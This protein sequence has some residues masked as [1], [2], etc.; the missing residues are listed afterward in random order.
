MELG[1]TTIASLVNPDTG[2][3]ALDDA[4][5]EVVHTSLADE[6]AQRLTVRLK[7]FRGEWF[8][9]LLEGTPYYERV[10]TKGVSDRV[11]QAVFGGVI[12][13][14]QGVSSLTSL[15]YS[16]GSDRVLTL[17]FVAK[18]EDGT[19]FST[20]DYPPFVVV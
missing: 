11:I 12:R 18:L 16:L 10:L 14:T 7:F 19:T 13:G 4:G 17:S 9:N 8:L 3:L 6:V 1:V 15:T 2:D 5:L 20:S